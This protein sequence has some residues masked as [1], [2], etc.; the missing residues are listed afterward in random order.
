MAAAWLA[1]CYRCF[2]FLLLLLCRCSLPLLLLSALWS[3]ESQQCHLPLPPQLH[4]HHHCLCSLWLPSFTHTVFS[5]VDCLVYVAHFV[6][7][8]S[9]GVSSPFSLSLSRCCKSSPGMMIY[10]RKLSFSFSF[11]SFFSFF[12]RSKVAC[13]CELLVVVVVMVAAMNT[14]DLILLD[15]LC[16]QRFIFVAF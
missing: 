15:F 6:F 8:V 14:L 4:H 11:L 7:R 1:S 10:P 13:F 5:F 2:L 3:V 9:S 12:F 16:W